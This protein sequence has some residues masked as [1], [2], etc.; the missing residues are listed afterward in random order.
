VVLRVTDDDGA[1]ATASKTITVNLA[2]TDDT[3]GPGTSPTASFTAT[4]LT[5]PAP[6]TVTFN[7]SASSHVGFTITAYFWTFDDGTTG[8]GMTTTHTY[9]P[10]ATRTYHVVLRIISSD[11][12]KEATTSKDL[13]ATVTT[14]T[15]PSS[16]PTASFTVSPNTGTAPVTVTFDPAGSSASTGHSIT[17]YVW[18]FGD[19]STK[20][21]TTKTT[22]TH[23]YITAQASQSFT[24]TL[25]VID[26]QGLT[27][28]TS[29]TVTVE[30]KQPV[31]G[32][33]MK[34]GAGAWVVAD[35]QTAGTTGVVVSF[36]SEEPNWASGTEPYN[37]A[38]GNYSSTNHNLSYDPE[39]KTGTYYGISNY[40]WRFGDGGSVSEGTPFA[41]TY[42]GTITHTY[43]TTDSSQTFTVTL[44]VTDKL[45]AKATTYTRQVKLG[46]P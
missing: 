7:A 11:N 13:I 36:R 18:N 38:P 2:D 26:D 40:T 1:R 15:P 17:T 9:A 10:S 24:A 33:E 20:T 5:G 32:F 16:A 22:V 31:A 29:R 35:V 4:P 43:A 44:E 30:D 8:A 6:L 19:Q 28:A 27:H 39:G 46:Q 37:A 25:T 34:L 12:N 41:S 45:G 42:A 14:P 3:D 21:E 23:P